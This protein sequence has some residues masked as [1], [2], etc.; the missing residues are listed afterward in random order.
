MT[1]IRVGILANIC[2]RCCVIA[3]DE[4]LGHRGSRVWR[5]NTVVVVVV[6]VT[7]VVVVAVV[8]VVS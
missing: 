2:G 5:F 6:V 1:E 8:A 3:Y 7:E 4:G